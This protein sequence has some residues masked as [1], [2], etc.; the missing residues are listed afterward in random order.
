MSLDIH[1]LQVANGSVV[2]QQDRVVLYT[3]PN[4]VNAAGGSAGASVT[5]AVAFGEPLPVNYS[6]SVTPSQAC[7]DAVTNKTQNGFNV[8]LTPT[9][10]SVT[11]GAGTFDVIVLA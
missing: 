1:T 10:S 6:V 7:F 3:Q 2:S 8:V 5:T 11:L 4:I 9:L